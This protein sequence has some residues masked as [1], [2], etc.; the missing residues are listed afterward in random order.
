MNNPHI[1][2]IIACNEKD[3]TPNIGFII[4]EKSLPTQ[5]RRGKYPQRLAYGAWKVW[6]NICPPWP[7]SGQW[8]FTGIDSNNF[9]STLETLQTLN[10]TEWTTVQCINVW[11]FF[12]KI[13]YN[14]KNKRYEYPLDIITLLK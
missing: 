2:F 5:P 1:N 3:D 14:Y 11:D 12:G 10:G 6:Q 4:P 7:F 8:H 9:F 13:G